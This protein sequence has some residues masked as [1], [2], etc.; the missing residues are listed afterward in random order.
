MTIEPFI[1]KGLSMAGALGN[2]NYLLVGAML[3]IG[4]HFAILLTALYVCF[5]RRDLLAWI[6]DPHD[7]SKGSA[8]Q[9]RATAFQAWLNG[10]AR[11]KRAPATTRRSPSRTYE[12]AAQ[13]AIGDLCEVHYARSEDRSYV[14]KTACVSGCDNLL[15][16]ERMILRQLRE[17]SHG[18]LSAEYF[19]VP[20]ESFRS[21]RRLV[22][23]F[24]WREGFLPAEEILRRHPRGVGGRHLAWMFNRT[25][26]ALGFSH[27]L[28]WIH[29]AVLPQHLL[30]NPETHGLQLVGWI[31]AEQRDSPL[32]IV[33][34]NFKA[35]YPPEC[36]QREAATPATDIYLAAKSI[37]WMA[38]GDPIT[39][40]TPPNLP[41]EFRGF[42]LECLLDSPSAR[43][44]DAWALHERFKELLE[45]VYGPPK[46][47]HLN[48]S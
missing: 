2:H 8:W 5:A 20:T 37:I 21:G 6:L 1:E 33:S 45:G 16:K 3:Y 19:P 39:N 48:M 38:G 32:R 34:R 42:L 47:C 44:Q 36:H 9:A 25:L 23:A 4:A 18:E 30:F 7:F 15:L 12:L 29:G 10:T 40:T 35:W 13:L 24:A 43:P 26:E 46:F 17:Q 14:L 31:H 22:S 11:P 41:Q 28:G 27:R